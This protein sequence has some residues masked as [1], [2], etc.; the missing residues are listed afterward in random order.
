MKFKTEK[1]ELEH[2]STFLDGCTL[3]V[4]HDEGQYRHL[5]VTPSD[6]RALW[7]GFD[8]ITWPGHI[9]LTGD[10]G[11]GWVFTR[12][13]QD[14][15]AY[16]VSGTHPSN[17]GYWAEKLVRACRSSPTEFSPK[18]F[19]RTLDEYLRD[20]VDNSAW[21]LFMDE[22]KSV[23]DTHEAITFLRGISLDLPDLYEYIEFEDYTYSFK[24]ACHQISWTVQTYLDQNQEG[25]VS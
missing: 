12:Y 24:R 18:L 19:L 2:L 15:M 14:D 23:E 13:G 1:E 9:A 17:Y 6:T 22:A 21:Q 10:L 8:V 16:W 11:D 5:H 3:T 25:G 4:L 20:Q 7:T